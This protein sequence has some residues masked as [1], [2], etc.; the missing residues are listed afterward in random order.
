MSSLWTLRQA[1]DRQEMIP[2]ATTWSFLVSVPYL[3]AI[4]ISDK[5]YETITVNM[6]AK[7]MRYPLMPKGR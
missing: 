4:T 3:I 2:Y 5:T 6:Y 1:P 7:S